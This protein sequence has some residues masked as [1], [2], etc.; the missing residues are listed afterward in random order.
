MVD[1]HLFSVLVSALSPES[2]LIL[3]GD[4][5]QLPSVETGAVL[6]DLVGE[7][8]GESLSVGGAQ[9]LERTMEGLPVLEPTSAQPSPHPLADRLVVLEKS[10]RSVPEI[11]WAARRIL[12]SDTAWAQSLPAALLAGNAALPV[13]R[14]VEG[15]DPEL[16]VWTHSICDGFRQFVSSGHDARL[17]RLLLESKR[18]L[19]VLHGGPCGRNAL[20]ERVDLAVR[21]RLA[22]R[23][24]GPYPGQQLLATQNRPDL[25]LRNGDLGVVATF[26][27]RLR[28]AFPGGSGIRWVDLSLAPE[29]EPA[30]ALTVHKAQGSEFDEVL[31]V[32]PEVDTP[33]LDRPIVYTALTRARRIVR[34]QGDPI[35]LARALARVPDRPSRLRKVLGVL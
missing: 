23:A 20:N 1:L 7:F 22:P 9:W 35:L 2:T 11:A 16:G 30:W 8:T 28:A 24:H 29:L 15:I 3:L 14:L 4:R 33:L 12:A 21:E 17:L 26:D 25:D 34:V 32:L 31:I 27:G 6:S 13:S 10:F 5:D 19:C 18:I